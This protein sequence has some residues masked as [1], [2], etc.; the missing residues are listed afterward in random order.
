MAI[1]DKALINS[2]FDLLKK[3]GIKPKIGVAT[4]VTRL[5]DVK[6]SFNLDF[7]KFGE[8]ADPEKLKK[9]VET[10]ALF[11]SKASDDELMQFRNN[12]NYL[13][14]SYPEIFSKAE[15]AV[16]TKT[17]I[18]SLVDDLNTQLSGKKSMEVVDPRT[19]EI[20]SPKK[21]ITTAE[22]IKR[23]PTKEE[24]EEYSQILDDSENF[25]VQGNETF[26]EL[27]ALVKKQKDYEDYMF[28]QYKRGKL[29]PVAG[30][31][32]KDR[33]D[34]LRK[35]S[36]EAGMVGDRRLFTFD[37]MRELQDLERKFSPMGVAKNEISEAEMIKQKYGKIID[38][39]LL[40][41]ILIDDNPQR[42]AEVM[43]TIDEALKMQEK[44]MSQQEIMD[45]M[46]NTP[47]TKQAAGGLIKGLSYKKMFSDLDRTL[48]KG[49][50]TMF[51]RKK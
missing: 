20:T 3:M 11:L 26:E 30:E 12:L 6:S 34:F 22:K 10:D 37:E 19:G 13:N 17:G 16:N 29:D 8:R 2:I 18:D 27:D 9:L 40:Q 23:K 45:I 5:P 50:G 51:K 35:K 7:T 43:A 24:Y 15:K 42:K 49:L 33:M 47:R 41:K 48:D 46:K 39:N 14:K 28:M 1:I 44:G 4:D 25:V 31:G 21:P 38:D 32:T 36:E